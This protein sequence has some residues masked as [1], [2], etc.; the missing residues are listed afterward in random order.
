MSMLNGSELGADSKRGRTRISPGEKLVFS[1]DHRTLKQTSVVVLRPLSVA[2][3]QT[4]K[5]LPKY[6]LAPVGIHR[7]WLA[8]IQPLTLGRLHLVAL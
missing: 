2:A 5:E 6:Y 1:P 8:R 4:T 7:S 3:K